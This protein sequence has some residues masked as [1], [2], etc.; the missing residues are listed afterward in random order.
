MLVNGPQIFPGKQNTVP[1]LDQAL[2]GLNRYVTATKLAKIIE[3]SIDQKAKVSEVFNFSGYFSSFFTRGFLLSR[4]EILIFFYVQWLR[5]HKWIFKEI[6]R[7][8]IAFHAH[9]RKKYH[10]KNWLSHAL[11]K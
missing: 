1:L 7:L 6:F 10:A 4:R 8:R 3:S 9:F 5:F 2:K 11:S